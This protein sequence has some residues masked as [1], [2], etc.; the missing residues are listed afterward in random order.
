MVR[1]I[2]GLMLS[3][4]V[5]LPTWSEETAPLELSGRVYFGDTG[6]PAEGARVTFFDL[7]NLQNAFSGVTD[8]SGSFRVVLIPAE[9]SRSMPAV[10]P[11]TTAP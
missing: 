6:A 5:V 9:R 11:P 3:L 4:L 2:T 10:T 1:I 8:A 7:A